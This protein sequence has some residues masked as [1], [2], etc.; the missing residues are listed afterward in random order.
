[1]SRTV[2]HIRVHPSAKVIRASA[3]FSRSRLINVELHDG[4]EVIERQ[5]F[6]DCKSLREILFRQGD[7]GFFILQL[8]GVDDCDS[9]R[10]ARGDW[11]VGI[12]TM[13]IG[14]HCDTPHRQGDW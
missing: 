14:T 4:I 8:L 13:R 5:A 1:M 7:Q 10:W 12:C 9:Q 2:C 11:G 3:F 6:Q